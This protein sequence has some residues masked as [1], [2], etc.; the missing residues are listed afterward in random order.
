LVTGCD[1][2][3]GVGE[4]ITCA[5]E[6]AGITVTVPDDD[7][8]N[9]DDARRLV[10]DAAARH[11]RLDIL[12]N[13]A[14]APQVLDLGVP[15]DVWDSVIRVNL[16]GTY[17]VARFVVPVMRGQRYG[18]IITIA[19]AASTAASR[20]AVLGFT[21]A[22]SAEVAPWGITANAIT[23]GHP[24]D[25]A[26]AVAYLASEAGGD[27]TGQMLPVPLERKLTMARRTSPP[28]RADHVGSLRRG[29]S[30]SP[31]PRSGPAAGHA[32]GTRSSATISPT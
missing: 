13:N 14:V 24:G 4:K 30:S 23:S 9:E 8:G 26:D 22:L 10:A 16:R 21:R 31:R 18:R 15:A 2:Q 20:A 7:I 17:L 12:V 11:G 25:V 27:L 28:F 6:A 19:P 1:K 5:L 32:S 3:D 29:R